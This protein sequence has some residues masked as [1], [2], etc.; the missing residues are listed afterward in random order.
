MRACAEL[1]IPNL[2]SKYPQNVALAAHAML[3]SPSRRLETPYATLRSC[4]S[5]QCHKVIRIWDDSHHAAANEMSFYLE[6][7]ARKEAAILT[8]DDLDDEISECTHTQCPYCA[9]IYLAYRTRM[10]ADDARDASGRQ[11]ITPRHARDLGGGPLPSCAGRWRT[12]HVALSLPLPDHYPITT[13]LT[14]D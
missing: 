8:E 11:P 1:P 5:A 13:R 14:Y 7:F 6:R 4:T 12:A 9:H 10:H 2:P 3:V